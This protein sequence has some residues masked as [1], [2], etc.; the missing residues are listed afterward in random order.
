MSPLNV[1]ETGVTVRR[2]CAH[3]GL[4]QT[5]RKPPG[6]SSPGPPANCPEQGPGSLGLPCGPDVASWGLFAY[7]QNREQDNQ[8]NPHDHSRR[9]VHTDCLTHDSRWWQTAMKSRQA[10]RAKAAVLMAEGRSSVGTPAVIGFRPLQG[11][12]LSTVHPAAPLCSPNIHF[13]KQ[14]GKK[15]A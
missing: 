4:H 14:T 2:L 1:E 3:L 12:T 13:M 11:R 6:A 5:H 8:D 7:K 10:E 9:L 15:I